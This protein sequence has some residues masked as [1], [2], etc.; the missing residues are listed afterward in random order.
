MNALFG[1]GILSITAFLFVGVL[2]KNGKTHRLVG[3][4]WEPYFA[5]VFVGGAALGIGLMALWVIETLL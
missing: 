5:I 1:I 4:Q 3:T 2:P